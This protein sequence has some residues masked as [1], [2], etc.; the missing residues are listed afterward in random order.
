[1]RRCR[2]MRL[3]SKRPAHREPS[4][5]R[6]SS[7]DGVPALERPHLGRARLRRARGTPP[8]PPGFRDPRQVDLT[9]C[10]Q[11]TATSGSLPTCRRGS[12]EPARL[13]YRGCGTGSH[14]ASAAFHARAL[15]E[16]RIDPV[17]LGSVQSTHAHP[18]LTAETTRCRVGA[19]GDVSEP[20][21]SRTRPH[22]AAELVL[23]RR[24]RR[25]CRVGGPIRPWE[26]RADLAGVPRDGRRRSSACVLCIHARRPQLGRRISPAGMAIRI[27]R[28]R[29]RHWPA[30]RSTTRCLV[31]VSV[32]G[33][34]TGQAP[35]MALNQRL[36]RPRSGKDTSKP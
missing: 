14:A 26:R 25:G 1:M 5:P 35:G 17:R 18:L 19:L 21:V 8:L 30:G 27:D 13:K 31:E 33:R 11:G 29:H 28:D 7:P 32:T 22:A 3:H 23:V 24:S 9:G 15:F 10:V 6:S 16:S 36:D 20:V 4:A 12:G 34:R 2:S